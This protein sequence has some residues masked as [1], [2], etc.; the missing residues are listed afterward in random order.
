MTRRDNILVEIG[1]ECDAHWALYLECSR[2]AEQKKIATTAWRMFRERAQ[3]HL[4]RYAELNK[5]WHEARDKWEREFL[6]VYPQYARTE[7]PKP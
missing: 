7:E 1:R 3:R 5:R 6:T 4:G 2:C